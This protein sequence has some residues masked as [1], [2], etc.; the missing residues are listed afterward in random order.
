MVRMSFSQTKME[1]MNQIFNEGNKQVFWKF[2]YI[3]E[4]FSNFDT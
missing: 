4:F 2:N 3:F 1:Q